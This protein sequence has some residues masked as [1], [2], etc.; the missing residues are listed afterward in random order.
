MQ[1]TLDVQASLFKVFLVVKQ[2]CI[3]AHIRPFSAAILVI[4]VVSIMSSC[5]IFIVVR[6]EEVPSFP[7]TEVVN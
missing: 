2:R 6:E 7:E 3:L 1:G 5:Y 4:L